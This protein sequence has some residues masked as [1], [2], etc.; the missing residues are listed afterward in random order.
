MIIDSHC[1][2]WTQW[3]YQPAVPDPESRASVEQLLHEMD[4]N[5]VD[6]ALIVCAE[7]D[8][9]PDNNQF[10]TE[11]VRRYP[12]RLAHVVDIDSMWKPTYHQPGAAARL[13]RAIERWQP[14][15]FTHYLNAADDGAW[16]S[17]P[18][19]LAFFAAAADAHLIASIHCHP[20][21]QHAIRTVAQHFPELPI[22]I[23]HL[24]H[25]RAGDSA[26]LDAILAS[27]PYEN[28][29]IKISGFYYATQSP[30]WDYPYADV[31]PIVRAIYA[32]FGARRLCWGSDY[33][34][35]RGFMTYRQAL[36]AF[37]THCD[38]IPPAE[39]DEILGGTMQRLLRPAD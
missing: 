28:I 22:L 38:F 25:P 1:H 6:Q 29:F 34:V 24:G 26:H 39:R 7:I 18:D 35:A 13:H 19:G 3:P 27:A 33:P 23:H 30:A 12:A 11:A 8:N 31:F 9:N 17:S 20:H 37:R 36:E 21:Q 2:A 4:V 16:C 14:N 5:G 10:I 15:G 32:Q